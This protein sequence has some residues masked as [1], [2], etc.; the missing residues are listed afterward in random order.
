MVGRLVFTVAISGPF[1]ASTMYFGYAV[2]VPWISAAFLTAGGDIVAIVIA[3]DMCLF[4]DRII[5]DIMEMYEIPE[6]RVTVGEE[7]P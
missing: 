6:F 7:K 1:L 5:A 2:D 4:K 3:L